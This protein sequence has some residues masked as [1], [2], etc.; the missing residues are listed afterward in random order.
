MFSS[1]MQGG[2]HLDFRSPLPSGEL[3]ITVQSPFELWRLA[4]VSGLTFTFGDHD[5]ILALP[6]R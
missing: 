1:G 2:D 3:G 6:C 5:L 4:T